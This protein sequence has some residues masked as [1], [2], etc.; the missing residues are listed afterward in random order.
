MPAPKEYL[1]IE[2]Y[3]APPQKLQ[4]MLIE[5]A[6]RNLQLA[7]QFWMGQQDEAGAERI[8]RAQEIV[9][10]LLAGLDLQSRDP[11]VQRVAGVYTYLV[12]ALAR[13]HSPSDAETLDGVLRVLEIERGTWQEIY[14]QLGRQKAATGANGP[15]FGVPSSTV[16]HAERFSLEA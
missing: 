13:V 9:G 6:I 4:L 8:M 15:H 1:A 10:Q 14:R 11:L 7:R 2:V 12:R 3:T 16:A 5:G